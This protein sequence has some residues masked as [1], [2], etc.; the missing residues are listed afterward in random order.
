MTHT[1]M[2]EEANIDLASSESCFVRE[3]RG[4]WLI[5]QLSVVLAA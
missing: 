1:V 3:L 5:E 2:I 4:M